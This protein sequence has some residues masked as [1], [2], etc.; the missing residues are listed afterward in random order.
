MVVLFTERNKYSFSVDSCMF[1]DVSFTGVSWLVKVISIRP[2]TP[3]LNT[4][5][6]ELI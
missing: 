4:G 3:V 1:N 6:L 2:M 5:P